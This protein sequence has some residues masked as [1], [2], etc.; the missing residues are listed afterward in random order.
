MFDDLRQALRGIRKQPGFAAV[1]VLTLA[2]GIG[3]NT[4]IFGIVSAFFLQPSRLSNVRRA[5]GGHAEGGDHQ[6]ALRAL[7]SGLPGL[8]EIVEHAHQSRR[9]HA[10]AGP[11]EHQ[12]TN[13]GAHVGRSGLAELLRAGGVSPA[14]GELLKPEQGEAKGAGAGHRAL[15]PLLAAPVR[16][17]PA[18]VGQ[19]IV[20]NGQS[21]TVVGIAPE[22]FTGLSW[23]MAVSGWV[24]TGAMGALM[25]N[26][27]AIRD[28]RA[29]PMFRLMG[30]L[31][32]G[33]TVADARAELEVI[34][35]RLATAY[36]AEHK[37][38]RLM[39]IPEN[40]ARPDPSV[41]EAAARVR[42][43]V[44]RH[45]DARAVHR[46]RQRGQPDGRARARAAAR[47]R[48]PL[49]PRRQSRATDP[50]PGRRRT[51][52]RR[53]RRR[54]RTPARAVGR[55]RARQLRPPGRHSDQPG[56]AIG[57]AG[58]GVHVRRLGD[59]RHRDLA[60]ARAPGLAIQ[61]RRVAEGWGP[62]VR[63]Q[64]ARVPQP[65]R[66]RPGEPLVHRA[67]QRRPVRPQPAADA[68]TSRSASGP[69]GCS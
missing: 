64:A 45:G 66:H 25:Q 50:A 67:R 4:S 15:L 42:R 29:A 57:L 22:S 30:R 5:R 34:A 23:A 17:Q 48:H 49:G 32:P 47:P 63:H 3:V 60:L 43:G 33:R 37:G 21:F 58:L 6:P 38:T 62:R 27:D 36:P 31:A 28:A 44:R 19:P 41:A 68:D 65:A 7:L 39:V 12:G 40:R 53:D 55:A 69:T 52:A 2:L 54:R 13:A 16:R 20:L 24:P 9:V 59:G 51:R 18:I 61:P 11:P 35:Q 10:D 14:A 56:P 26:G 46:L 8:P 1:A